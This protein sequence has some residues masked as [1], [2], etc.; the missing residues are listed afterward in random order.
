LLQSLFDISP[1][2][3]Y[4]SVIPGGIA[5]INLITISY[6]ADLLVVNTFQI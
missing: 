4:L 5:E 6:D 1:T 2:N 3:A